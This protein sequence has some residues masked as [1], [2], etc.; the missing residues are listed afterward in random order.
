MEKY[1]PEDNDHEKWVASNAVVIR[2]GKIRF[3]SE[4]PDP[5]GLALGYKDYVFLVYRLLDSGMRLGEVARALRLDKRTV[6]SLR[7]DCP[8]SLRK[9]ISELIYARKN[10]NKFPNF[11]T[12]RKYCPQL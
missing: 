10:L 5:K 12:S 6:T 8:E 3:L 4:H 9:E 1:I 11:Q 7:N 2:T